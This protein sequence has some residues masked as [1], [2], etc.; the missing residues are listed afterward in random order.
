MTPIVR[1]DGAVVCDGCLR[2]AVP[3]VGTR[4]GVEDVVTLWWS[5]AECADVSPAIPFP[6]ELLAAALPGRAPIPVL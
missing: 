1:R 6:A 3:N 5:C 2:P 4:A